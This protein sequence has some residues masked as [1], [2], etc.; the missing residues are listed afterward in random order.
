MTGDKLTDKNAIREEIISFYKSLIGT[1]TYSLPAV[2]R[3]IIKKGSVLNHRQ[4]IELYA[5]VSA[6]EI[7]EGLLFY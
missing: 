3:E 7:Y 1:T 6:G 4:Q 2:N 5:Q